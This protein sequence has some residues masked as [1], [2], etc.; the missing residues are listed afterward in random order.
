MTDFSFIQLADPQ[1]GM[2]AS[3]SKK[4]DAEIAAFAE[5]GLMIRKT[6]P[7]EGFAPETGLFT[8]AIE[9]ANSL[10]PAFVV[11][12]GDITNEAGDKEQITEAKR[13]AAL[14]DESIALHWVPGNHD[15]AF[16]HNNPSKECV[17]LYREN[18]GPDYYSFSYGAVK[19]IVI[20][21]TVL[22]TPET[23]E[24]EAKAQ[25]AFVETEADNAVNQNSSRIILFSHH[26][27]FVESPDE[28]NNPWSIE[29]KYRMPLLR[30]A[31][32][33]GI[34]ANFAGHWHHNNIASANGIETVASGPVGYPLG[35]DPSGYRVVNV[36]S[37]GI[38]H[39]Y[40]TL[41]TDS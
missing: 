38:T 15:V 10:K 26:P 36:T 27:L 9:H 33:H 34:E 37:N 32:K 31:E 30:I 14:L 41:E 13:I 2:F 11:V 23:M 40:H 21:S 24:Q 29:K 19:F 18:F 3:V 5:R 17:E 39:T 20:N 22:T 16:D 28:S 8:R 35:D 12:C 7:I 25:I 1:F 6:K 4:T